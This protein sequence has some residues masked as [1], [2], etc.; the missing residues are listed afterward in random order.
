M[1]KRGSVLYDLMKEHQALEYQLVERGDKVPS[2]N[3]VNYKPDEPI[4]R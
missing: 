2:A 4:L 3:L 1:S